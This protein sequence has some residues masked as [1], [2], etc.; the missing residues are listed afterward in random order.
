MNKILPRIES[1]ANNEGITIGALERK[2]GAS[3]GVLSRAI[4]NGTD[5]QSKWIQAIVEN[6]PRYSAE[7]LLSGKGEM[8]REE[9]T[10]R[11]TPTVQAQFS[12]RTDHLV[13]MQNVPLY[14]LDASAGLVALFAD[15]NRRTPISHIQIPDLPPCDGAVYVRGDSM[16]PLLKSG[17]IV[18]YK[19]IP[20]NTVGRDVPFVIHHRR[21][22]LYLDQIH[23]EGRRQSFCP[24]RKPQPTPFAEG[25]PGRLNPGAGINQSKYPVQ[26]DGINSTNHRTRAFRGGYFDQ[27]PRIVYV[28]AGCI[29]IYRSRICIIPT[30]IHNITHDL[31]S[32]MI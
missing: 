18:L 3:K 23:P 30:Y 19:E 4:A 25:Y 6:Y 29:Y 1:I 21:R 10:Q 17:D 20:R 13:E 24:T 27:P 14:E 26:Y 12:L 8:I 11:A 2:I 22:E 16:Y 5:I 7:W 32:L 31:T 15:Q 9:A 28:L